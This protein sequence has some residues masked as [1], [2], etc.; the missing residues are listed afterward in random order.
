MG[1]PAWLLKLVMAFL[2]NRKMYTRYKG[3]LSSCKSLP[4]GGP[5]GTLLG[6][7]LFI[8]LINNIGF[9]NQVNN[10]GELITCRRK[11]SLLNEIHLKYVDDLT[12]GEA[13]N[14][15]QLSVTQAEHR[16][17]RMQSKKYL[18]FWGKCP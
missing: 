9:E 7:L 11:L 13:I 6:L 5:Q 3:K 4:G 1:V 12:L 15:K 14:L 18:I 8:V 17:L 10:V 16:T 2:S